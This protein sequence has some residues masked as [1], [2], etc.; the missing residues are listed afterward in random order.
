LV[1][2]KVIR[3][4]ITYNASSRFKLYP[5]GDIHAGSIHCAEHEISNKIAEIKLDKDAYIIG[6]GDYADSIVKDDFRFDIDGLAPWVS[7]SNIVESQRKW[8]VDL[9]SPVKEKIVCLL[10]GN[11]EEAIHHN[12][13]DDITL[14]IANDLD[15]PWAGYAAFIELLFQRENSKERHLV[16]IHAWHG[17]GA[18]QTE[19]ARLNR[20]MRLVNEVQ[21]DVYL[22]G[23][24]HCITQ[25]TPERLVCKNGVI[26]SQKL[27]AVIT[28]S[29][30]RT[31]TQGDVISYGEKQGYKPTRIGCPVIHIKP[32]DARRIGAYMDISI[33]A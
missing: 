25:H 5:I 15:V 11:H 22:M 3:K 20:L 17:A 18:A 14:N 9:F 33:E 28:G 6:I 13:Q 23:H 12:F 30:L 8:I 26:R 16:V 24:L 7:K 32:V 21:A 19:G 27:S 1:D 10:T 29:W 4:V 2:M 31:Y